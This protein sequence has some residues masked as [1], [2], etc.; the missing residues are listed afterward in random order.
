MKWESEYNAFDHLQY[1]EETIVEIAKASEMI[2]KQL[3]DQSQLI[4][5]MIKFESNVADVITALEK[6]IQ[7]LENN[8]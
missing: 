4:H 8:G 3:Q 5:Q 1:L 2:A 7:Y 6:R